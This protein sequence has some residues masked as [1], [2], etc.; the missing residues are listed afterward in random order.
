M[1]L[2]SGNERTLDGNEQ[3]KKPRVKRPKISSKVPGATP[4]GTHGGEAK[5]GSTPKATHPAKNLG[6]YLHKA[7][8]P[9]GKKIGAAK[10]VANQI[11]KSKKKGIAL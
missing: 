3:M 4:K 7:K 9:S 11:I 1:N 6:K 8:M 2:D 5:A 10:S